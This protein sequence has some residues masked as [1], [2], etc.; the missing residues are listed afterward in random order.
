M[1][2]GLI[3]E[4]LTHSY[5]CEIHREIG[6][7][8]YELKELPRSA[9]ADFFRKREFLA[10]NVTIPYKTEIMQY[11]DFISERARA[12][13]AVNTVVNNNGK[14]YGYNTD[15]A[16]MTDML[17]RNGIKISGKKVLIL[18]TGGTSKTAR[19]VCAAQGAKE[20]KIV[21]R[22][23]KDGVISY[24]DAIKNHNDAQ[25]I[26]NTT[27]VGMYPHSGGAPIDISKFEK[28]EGVA[29]AIYNP[30]CSDIVLYAKKRGIP[31]CGGLYMLAS[32]AVYAS[33]L[34][35]GKEPHAEITEQVYKNIYFEKQNIVL[36]GMPA[37]GKTTV[38]KILAE[39]TGKAFADTDE[40]ITEKTGMEISEY[41]EKFGEEKFREIEKEVISD[42]S[43]MSG[44]II[45][46]GGGAAMNSDNIHALKRNGTVVLLQRELSKLI[47]TDDRPLARDKNAVAALYEKRMP[48]YESAADFAADSNST[49]EEAADNVIKRLKI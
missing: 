30:L 47:P 11:L 40:L 44:L 23:A 45:S 7:Y 31:A 12:V 8:E 41:F 18:G 22:S 36:I 28:L 5:S 43:K 1:L 42:I 49:P 37:S 2:Y 32:Q 16:G 9:L 15:F 38:G 6:D 48:V 33:A 24:E 29:D 14:L 20:V 46:T 21:S 27:P 39:K 13:G 10:I 3:G 26:I 17:N 25:I 35:M 19:A 4:H 34:F